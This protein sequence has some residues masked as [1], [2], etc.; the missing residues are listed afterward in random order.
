MKTL[1]LVLS[2]R[3][4]AMKSHWGRLISRP[5]M[6]PL[7]LRTIGGIISSVSSSYILKTWDELEKGTVSDEFLQSVDAIFLSGLSTAHFGMQRIAKKAHSFNKPVIAGGMGVT[8]YYDQDPEKN[9]NKLWLYFDSIC[10]GQ[11]TQD[12]C[13]TILSDLELGNLQQL[14]DEGR[15]QPKEWI[16]PRHDLARGRYIFNDVVASSNGCKDKCGFC[17][18]HKCL[19]GCKRGIIYSKPAEMYAEEVKE[20][21]GSWLF[22]SAD[23]VGDDYDHYVN[24]ILPIIKTSG[25]KSVLEAKLDTLRGKD[26]KWTLFTKMSE[27]GLK[28]IY[29]SVEDFFNVFTRK[30][31]GLEIVEEAIDRADDMGVIPVCSFML[32]GSSKATLESIRQTFKESNR[33]FLDPQFSLTSVLDGSPLKAE[34]IQ[35]G[36]LI[37]ENQEFTCGAWPQKLH[38][39][40]SPQELIEVL[41]EGYKECYSYKQI[42]ARLRHRGFGKTAIMAALAGAGVHHSIKSWKKKNRDYNYW[43]EHRIKPKNAQ[44]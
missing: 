37:D 32:D 17:V 25:K 9:L 35:D 26:G 2:D 38:P 12:V 19:P 24:E 7:V 5:F 1:G 27:A 20:C 13:A 18:V 6:A 42:I 16:K 8:C 14:Y 39:N 33:L 10:V 31:V 11:L 43:L 29:F 4:D 22:D 28:V 44:F 36:T 40:V 15:N 41:A 3:R 34:T 21:E 23:S 30:Q